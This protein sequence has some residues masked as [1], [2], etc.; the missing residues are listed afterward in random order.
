MTGPA[1]ALT[2]TGTRTTHGVEKHG[3]EKRQAVDANAPFAL[4]GGSY[5]ARAGVLED[6]TAVWSGR[7]DGEFRHTSVAVLTHDP[8]GTT[9]VVRSKSTAK[10]VLWGGALLGGA[11]FVV[12]P[13]AGAELLAATG[14]SGAGVIVEHIHLNTDPSRLAEMTA[15]LEEGSFGLAV[16]VLNCHSQAVTPLL[17]HADRTIALDMSWGDLGEEL[18]GGPAWRD[19]AVVL[20]PR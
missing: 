7:Q 15:V 13:S 3:V 14:F 20:V 19:P 8:D 2:S 10:H 18:S 12:A 9:H 17:P 4:V 16:V 1:V 5:H 6:F 11:L